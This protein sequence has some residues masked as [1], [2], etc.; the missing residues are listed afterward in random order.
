MTRNR[1]PITFHIIHSSLPQIPTRCV[2][3][4][5]LD[6]KVSSGLADTEAL[7]FREQYPKRRDELTERL[8]ALYDREVFAGALKDVPIKWSKK[9]LKTAG[10]CWNH[11]RLGKRTA[12]VELS[13]KVLTSA[14]RL[15]CTLIHE[16]CHAAA[17]LV[18]GEKK[19]H[20]LPWRQWTQRA[21]TKLK[22]LPKITVRHSYDIQYKYTYQCV[23]C[24]A[25]TQMHSRTKKVESIRCRRCHG[26]IEILLNKRTKQ[27]Q[28][29][30]TP[31]RAASGF[32]LYVK[33]NYK[34]LKNP[35]RKHA[36]VMR[37][38]SQNFAEMK[39]QKNGADDQ[40]QP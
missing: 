25:K 1:F 34:K 11:S 10:R 40:G 27:G 19:G 28:V 26:P 31:V 36:D 7:V 35:E 15:R 24:M 13:E 17:W 18:D 12:E 38:L 21:E 23:K 30:E 4:A 6:A 2:F 39:V 22:G 8:R 5:S 16:M 33:E 9:L 14:D 20:G 37:L 29:V 32:A 3:L